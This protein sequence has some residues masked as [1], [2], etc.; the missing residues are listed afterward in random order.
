[1]TSPVY[2]PE[3]TR[4]ARRLKDLKHIKFGSTGW[5]NVQPYVTGAFH[6]E[7]MTYCSYAVRLF[8]PYPPDPL[9]VSGDFPFVS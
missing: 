5:P 9:L 6:M 8:P 1:M 4:D 2:E 3:K 7:N